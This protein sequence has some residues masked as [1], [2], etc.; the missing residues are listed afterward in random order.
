[1]REQQVQYLP[2]FLLENKNPKNNHSRQVG[3][4]LIILVKDGEKKFIMKYA[5][6]VKRMPSTMFLQKNVGKGVKN[7]F[8]ELEKLL[9]CIFF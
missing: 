1:M 2:V 7:R 9:N 8:M 6:V 4:Q 3:A 5:A